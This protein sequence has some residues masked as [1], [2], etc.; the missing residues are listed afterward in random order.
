MRGV[1]APRSTGRGYPPLFLAGR[2]GGPGPA[3]AGGPAGCDN[4]Q[5]N[6]DTGATR[7]D[8]EG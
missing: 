7:P 8:G 2:N 1:E 3:L 5:K 4:P 6:G